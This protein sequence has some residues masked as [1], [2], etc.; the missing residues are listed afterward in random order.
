VAISTVTL[1]CTDYLFK[2][3]AKERFAPDELGPFFARYYA[4]LNA[5]A[6]IIQLFVAQRVV[7]RMGV[8][9][10]LAV[11]PVLLFGGG[12]GVT[13]AGGALGL[14]L[15][16]KGADGTLRHS[17]HRVASEL[18][19]LPLPAEVRDRS[20]SLL[21][22]VFVRGAQALT[23]GGIL[24]CA[25]LELQSARFYGIVVAATSAVWL[26]ATALLQRGY[27]DVFRGELG[28]AE[29][30]PRLLGSSK[31]DVDSIEAV[32]S[33][34][35]SPQPQRVVAAMELLVEAGRARIV[36]AL[37]LYHESEDVL[38]KALDILPRAGEQDWRPH[39][40]RLLRTGTERVRAAALRALGRAC[41]PELVSAGLEDPSIAVRAH[42]AYQ[43]ARC[44]EGERP[45]RH[46][47][48]RRVLDRAATADAAERHTIH[49]ALV[50]E[51][52]E[53]ADDRFAELLAELGVIADPPLRET[54]ANAMARLPDERF[55]PILLTWLT[56]RTAH[57]PVRDALVAV[58][59]P[60]LDALEASLRDE[61]VP[62]ALRRQAPIAIAAFGS[63]RA[64]DVLAQALAHERDGLT[65]YRALRGLGKL[66]ARHPVTVDRGAVE[67]EME[68]NAVEHLRLLSSAW[69]LEQT[70]DQ[71]ASDAAQRSGLLLR[72][73]LADKANQAL[74]RTFR[75]FKLLHPRED[76]RA[77]YLALGSKD[78]RARA[79]ALEFFET[80]ALGIHDDLRD[81][82]RLVADDLAPA[83]RVR[84]A[85][86]WV[87]APAADVDG[88]LRRLLADNDEA[89][90]DLAARHAMARGATALLG[91]M[92]ERHSM[93]QV[94]QR[95]L[96]SRPPPKEHTDG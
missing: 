9:G 86:R 52:A 51:V 60:A 22:A 28:R 83:E 10:A 34:L 11:L 35:S 53:D 45:A 66:V 75:L 41:E 44:D 85:E 56:V 33:A 71:D 96:S 90:V 82:L 26:V 16:T 36:P 40:L 68:R 23:A 47:E 74:E 8:V 42:A 18:L 30:D 5:L 32:M 13:L 27:L 31:L 2:L 1:L 43:L 57:T 19:Y 21:D 76:V 3:V 77:I 88:A 37:V 24:L 15:L 69:P 4:L 39:A 58:G 79:N 49:L 55:V 50:E 14:V 29:L 64:A 7:R 48:L 91:G 93:W 81:L 87:K 65:R 70:A 38:I 61:S 63:Q 94:V 92:E 54:I 17:L 25:Q 67:R 73:L 46:P 72:G 89:V 80:L 59:S 20:K 84:R 95:R 12:A 62:L 6:L 78:R